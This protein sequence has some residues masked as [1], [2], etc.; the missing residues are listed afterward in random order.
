MSRK[1]TIL[2]AVII[3]AGLLAILFTT[4]IIYDTDKLIDGGE[5]DSALAEAPPIKQEKELS[6]IAAIPMVVDEM[7]QEIKKYVEPQP[8]VLE[9]ENL[10]FQD[11]PAPEVSVI[12]KP[13]KVANP[14][15][16]DIVVKK[17]DSLDKIAKANRTTIESIKKVNHL[18]SERLSIGQLLRVPIKNEALEQPF[19]GISSVVKEKKI[20][21]SEPVY[22]IVK[23]GDSPWKIARQ[24][25]VNYEQILKLN[26][27]DEDK[28]RN[29]KIGDRIRVK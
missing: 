24:Y 29:L 28:A 19:S 22:H 1:D 9:E 21:S 15:Y 27:L 4:A 3:N 18:T 14:D 8:V 5:L 11:V 25:S 7:D 2:I 23:S 16:V 13:E 20:D 12:S 17:G 10:Y 6:Y 26:H